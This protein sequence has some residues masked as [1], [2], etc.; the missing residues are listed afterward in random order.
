MPVPWGCTASRGS[1]VQ[2]HLQFAPVHHLTSAFWKPEGIYWLLWCLLFLLWEWKCLLWTAFWTVC[3]DFEIALIWDSLAHL[4]KFTCTAR[5]TLLFHRTSLSSVCSQNQ[6]WI[7]LVRQTA[8][9]SSH[10]LRLRSSWICQTSISNALLESSLVTFLADLRNQSH[11][12]HLH[13][14][15]S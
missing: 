8:S 6:A 5:R 7:V 14:S 2:K 12:H 9:H 4:S 15:V 13:H 1:I 11:N 10:L 3:Q